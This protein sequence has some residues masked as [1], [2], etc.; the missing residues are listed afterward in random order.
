[1]GVPTHSADDAAQHAF[2]VAVE[3]LPHIV[4]GCERAFL[5]ATAVR[6]AHGLRRKV[7]REVGNVNPDYDLSPLPWPDDLVDQK[8]ARELLD[9]ILTHMNGD[10]RLV[11]VLFEIEGR[12]IPEIAEA[13]AIPEGTAASRLRRARKQFNAMVRRHR[14]SVR[15]SG[16]I[17]VATGSVRSRRAKSP[18][19]S[20]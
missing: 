15:T 16:R 8:R 18:S 11:F 20:V 1:M 2:L 7:A 10:V 4:A 17:E 6:I 19:V 9:G 13:L 5:F 14:K 12:P 3:A